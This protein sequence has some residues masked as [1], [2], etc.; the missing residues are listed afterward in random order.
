MRKMTDLKKNTLQS[1]H[2]LTNSV[3]HVTE[4]IKR[5]EEKEL[6]KPKVNICA[7]PFIN[8]ARRILTR[9]QAELLI[10][11]DEEECRPIELLPSEL[12]QELFQEK[13]RV[14]AKMGA[15]RFYTEDLLDDITCAEILRQIQQMQR[16]KVLPDN[17]SQTKERLK[18]LKVMY[19]MF[20]E[21]CD[22]WMEQNWFTRETLL[23]KV[24]DCLELDK[25]NDLLTQAE[26]A[27]YVLFEDGVLS[28]LE[29]NLWNEIVKRSGKKN[30]TIIQPYEMESLKELKKKPI[31]FSGYGI[32]NEVNYVAEEIIKCDLRAGEVSVYYSNDV[33]ENYL[34]AV[35]GKRD[36]PYTFLSGRIA[37]TFPMVKLALDIL[38]FAKN[39][40]F[41]EDFEKIISCKDLRIKEKDATYGSP[42][43]I[44]REMRRD[45]IMWGR[46]AYEVWIQ[47]TKALKESEKNFIQ[48]LL[49][50]FEEEKDVTSMYDALYC[51]VSEYSRKGKEQSG[52]R[53][54]LKKIRT[55]LELVG[56]KVGQ[57][58]ILY[59]IQRLE[60]L[61]YTD[62][63]CSGA[64]SFIKIGTGLEYM[65]RTTNFVIGLSAKEFAANTV[66]SPVLADSEMTWCQGGVLGDIVLATDRDRELKKSVMNSLR[67]MKKDATLYLGYS[68]YNTVESREMNPSVFL[69]LLAELTNVELPNKPNGYKPL[70]MKQGDCLT[71]E[72]AYCIGEELLLKT[73]EDA[74]VF[75]ASSM[76]TLL[77]CPA[78]YLY[79]KNLGIQAY[80]AVQKKPNVWLEPLERGEL[81]HT[82]LEQYFVVITHNYAKPLPK[83]FDAAILLNV[84]NECVEQFLLKKPALSERVLVETK[85]EFQENVTKYLEKT[86]KEFA[87]DG[88]QIVGCEKKFQ[89]T[90]E[91]GDLEQADKKIPLLFFGSIDRID[92]RTRED[93]KKECRIIDYKS[94]KFS[95]VEDKIKEHQFVQDYVYLSALKGEGVLGGNLEEYDLSTAY[96]R[97]E[98]LEEKSRS[99]F[100][101]RRLSDITDCYKYMYDVMGRILQE[102]RVEHK[103]YFN[104]NTWSCK[105]CPYKMLC[106]VDRRRVK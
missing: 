86:H 57:E 51:F 24:C 96:M 49:H 59:L 41:C 13:I 101:E 72:S 102:Q 30:G 5:Q 90:E 7:E 89:F 25:N 26:A 52:Q 16:N 19:K 61:N 11:S 22:E 45:K 14:K 78:R 100:L 2:I 77:F 28:V 97:F 46:K 50:I 66:E 99:T 69:R 21:L 98:F 56:E 82:I 18:D 3:K 29:Q 55:S 34:A 1:C 106:D 94:G 64:V 42:E 20:E 71:E 65:E 91:I 58:A 36:I 70:R 6:G 15:F 38:Y 95:S 68:C 44:Y 73:E 53:A 75:S 40:F 9:Q 62:S 10:L 103:S 8:F 31:V 88:W 67:T 83:E 23:K 54:L 17:L 105:Y 81:Y 93:G 33:Y 79:E 47:N 74:Y 4:Y 76:Q 87:E 92:V 35:F 63:A 85:K 39:D 60:R 12:I 37:K 104:Q 80:D 32:D 43:K 27:S 84:L 48:N